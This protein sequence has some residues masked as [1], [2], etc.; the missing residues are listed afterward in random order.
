M[1]N[2]KAPGEDGVVLEAIKMRGTIFKECLGLQLYFP[3]QLVGG[4]RQVPT[5]VK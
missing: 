4:M 5:G 2:N 1:K 3:C